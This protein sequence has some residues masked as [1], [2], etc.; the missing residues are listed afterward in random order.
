MS[1]R[2]APRTT[3]NPSWAA[4]VGLL[5]VIAACG[6]P[7]FADVLTV[8]AAYQK[9]EF[10][11]ALAGFR[12]LA[13][14][15]EPAAQYNLA[16]MY[17]RGEG[18]R[19]NDV[20]AYAWAVISAEN[21]NPSGKGLAEKVRPYLAPGS[22]RVLGELES[23]FGPTALAERLLPQ[24]LSPEDDELA[25]KRCASVRKTNLSLG[26]PLQ[27]RAEGRQG[28]VFVGFTLMPDGHAQDPRILYI[29]PRKGFERDVRARLLSDRF[30]VAPAGTPPLECTGFYVF[31]LS[32]MEGSSGRVIDAFVANTLRQA[33]AGDPLA[34]LHYAMMVQSGVP[35][36]KPARREA[37]PW[38]VK[39]S[40]AGLPEAQFALG[41]CLLK[42]VGVRHDE[43]KALFWLG[44]AAANREPDAEVALAAHALAAGSDL[45]SFKRAMDWLEQA[46]EQSNDDGILYLSA[47]LAT[48]PDATLRDPQRSLTLIDA[49]LAKGQ[50]D[51]R[52][53]EVRAAALAA[54]GRFPEA[55]KEEQ[56]S[57]KLARAAE[58]DTGPLSERLASYQASRPWSG[59]LIKF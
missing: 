20:D 6:T 4:R 59:E 51:P 36:S 18:T 23:H 41:Y 2:T 33:K 44:K 24:A 50:A 29:I 9:G 48:A 53:F 38:F 58:W 35:A 15:G 21:G 16:V 27:A 8:Q 56:T 22:E 37:L 52:A 12:E 49:F 28:G 54:L 31:I 10:A 57:I 55:I 17:A 14:L 40:Q 25:Q 46:V 1:T 39:A 32:E 5:L 11:A 3:K 43:S 30:G 47:L 13:E 26:Y 19:K 34:Q 45:D 42:G 7:A